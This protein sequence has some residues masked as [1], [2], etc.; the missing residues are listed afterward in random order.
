MF[1]TLLLAAT[2]LVSLGVPDAQGCAS[3]VRLDGRTLSGGPAPF[4]IREAVSLVLENTPVVVLRVDAP[5]RF[6]SRIRSRVFVYRIAAGRLEPRF[7]GSGFTSREVTSL[8]V[9]DGALGLDTQLESG[10]HETLRCVFDGFPLVC[11]ELT[12]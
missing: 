12:P 9:L 10:A 1:L 6:E 3:E 5:H 11:S 2:P 7:L 8:L 4:C